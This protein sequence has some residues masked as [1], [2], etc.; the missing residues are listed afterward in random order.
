MGEFSRTWATRRT[1]YIYLVVFI[2]TEGGQQAND[3]AVR[4]VDDFP[5]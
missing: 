5:L 1:Q 3:R 2:G 4:H